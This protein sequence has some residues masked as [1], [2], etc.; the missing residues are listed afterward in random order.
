MKQD[1]SETPATA[2]GQ[3]DAASDAVVEPKNEKE[4]VARRKFLTSLAG[5]AGALA[6]GDQ[7]LQAQEVKKKILSRIQDEIEG[8]HMDDPFGYDNVSMHT[9]YTKAVGS[10]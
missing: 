3:P 4:P 7:A 9:K 8:D 6:I 1:D 10:N 5:A 2:Q